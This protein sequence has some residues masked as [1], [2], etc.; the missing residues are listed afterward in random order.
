MSGVLDHLPAE[1]FG[2]LPPLPEGYVVVWTEQDEMYYFTIRGSDIEGGGGWDRYWV[3]RC[4]LAHANKH[5]SVCQRSDG[6][7][8]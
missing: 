2:A 3:R 6:V 8:E 1:N 7:P 5:S 4:A